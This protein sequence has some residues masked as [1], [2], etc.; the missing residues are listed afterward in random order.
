MVLVNSIN[1]KIG[2]YEKWGIE[3]EIRDRASKYPNTYQIALFACC[4]EIFSATKH[5]GLFAGTEL[6]AL[7]HFSTKQAEEEKNKLAE[8]ESVEELKRKNKELA[9][10][11]G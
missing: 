8:F 2:F 1:K 7:I 4:R 10:R 6:Q 3:Y 11:L 5:C 9:E